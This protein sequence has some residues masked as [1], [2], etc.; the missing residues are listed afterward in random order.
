MCFF[1]FG[2]PKVRKSGRPMLQVP[3]KFLEKIAR[4]C[5][6]SDIIEKLSTPLRVDISK[7]KELLG[8]YPEQSLEDG[9]KETVEWFKNLACAIYRETGL[10]LEIVSDMYKN[11]DA[12]RRAISFFWIDMK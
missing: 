7:A 2:G 3:V 6:K 1:H 5:G 11:L 9:L 10:Y 12:K 4:L 8:W